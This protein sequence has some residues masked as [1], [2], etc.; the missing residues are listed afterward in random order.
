[1]RKRKN[2]S[3]EELCTVCSCY[4]ENGNTLHHVKSRGSMGPEVDWNEMP[5]CQIHHTEV[6][7]SKLSS[8]SRKYPQVKTWLLNH[9][10]EMI[11]VFGKDKWFHGES[12][13][14]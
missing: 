8:F 4:T 7:A 3:T 14:E 1:M 12:E 9:E 2:Y 10:W 13:G 6:H 5:L 11:S